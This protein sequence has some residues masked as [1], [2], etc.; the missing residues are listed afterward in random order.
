MLHRKW[1][2]YIAKKHINGDLDLYD[3]YSFMTS[4]ILAMSSGTG[5]VLDYGNAR[6]YFN[7]YTL[8]IEPITTD[9]ADFRKLSSPIEKER[10]YTWFLPT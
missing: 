8:K 6:Y 3:E 1:Y 5:H 2:S 4:L 10:N 9:Q 7:P